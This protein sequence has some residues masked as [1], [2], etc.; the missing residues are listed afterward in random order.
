MLQRYVVRLEKCGSHISKASQQ[1]IQR[2]HQEVY[3]SIYRQHAHQIITDGE[4]FEPLKRDVCYPFEI[5]HKVESKKNM[6]SE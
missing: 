1:N 3:G 4:P 6:L 2:L 5:Q